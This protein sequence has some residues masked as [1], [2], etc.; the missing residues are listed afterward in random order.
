MFL[1]AYRDITER[2]KAEEALKRAKEAAEEATRAKSEFL[3]VMSHEIRTPMNSVVGMTDLLLQTSLT[4]EQRE[5]AET[6]RV[7]G[8][9]LLTVINDIL[10]FSKIE[11]GK[12]EFEERPL[13]LKTCIEEVLDLFSHKALEKGLDLIYWIDPNVPPHIVGDVLRLRQIL[14]N[15]I[16][17]A[18]KFTDRGEVFVSVTLSWK[19]G[20]QLALKFSVKDTG[21]GISADKVDR[22]FKAFSQVDSSTTRKY[23]G[24]G[25][26][27]AISQRLT[28]LM[29]GN[30]W[31]ESEPGK[32]STFI[33]TIKTSSPP[34]DMMLPKVYLRSKVP[35]LSG[36]RVLVVDDNETNLMILRMYCENW[37]M[38]PRT[39]TSPR[40]ALEWVRKGDPFDVA[41]LD[42][43]IPEMDGVELARELRS[44]RSRESLPLILCSSS[45]QST[46]NSDSANVFSAILTKPIKQD[47]IFE[48]VMTAVTGKQQ[49]IKKAPLPAPK[50]PAELLPLSILVAEDNPVNQKLLVRVLQQLCYS[51]DLADNGV[52]VLKAVAKKRYN[53]IFMDVHMPEMD[54]LEAARRIV[55]D[56]GQGERP[57]IV[58]VT[59]DAL[60]GDREKCIEAGMDDYIT[61]PIRVA[62]IQ[63]VLERWGKAAD[64]RS[65]RSVTPAAVADLG[66]LEKAMLKRMEQLGIETD[67]AFM[68]EL[69]DTYAPSFE[70]QF[71]LMVEACS[72]RDAHNLHQ[73]AH[74]LKGAGLN[75]GAEEF[76]ALCR[77]IEDLSFESDFESVANM[78]ATLK[79]EKQKVLQALQVVKNR[80]SEQL[81]QTGR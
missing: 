16:N 2:K 30:I 7:G 44:L 75:I 10:D 61:K 17:N 55:N 26:G 78:I 8:E 65:R 41:I 48:T 62:D 70:K 19:L 71:G 59:A 73:A 68:I 39:S 74:S 37:G 25:L 72:K 14:I 18:I 42:M 56:A 31:A 22:L 52:E 79:Q 69:I 4:E 34:A 21:I 50:A 80:L 24:T 27:L 76:G 58:A 45:G 53:L 81:A 47:Q 32:G 11:S 29:G 36:K 51:A 54:G 49:A 33:F 3:A 12:I 6:I 15:L 77:K 5:F 9:S 23:G 35:E 28:E 63:A 1:S 66:P 20:D 38:V 57:I 43:M 64:D 13:E 40:K 46:I 67:Y 60:Q